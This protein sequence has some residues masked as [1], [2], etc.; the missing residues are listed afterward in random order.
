MRLGLLGGTFDPIHR[1]HLDAGRVARRSL[2]LDRVLLVPARVPP[3]RAGG[4][5]ASGYHRFAMAVLAAQDAEGFEVSDIELASPGPSYT[6]QTLREFRRL[7]LDASQMFFISGVDA[8]A[9]I[10]TWHDYPELL[11][12]AHWV[13]VARPGHA[14]A[15]LAARLPEVVGRFE[16]RDT[17]AIPPASTADRTRVWLV[18]A[19]TTDVS[20]TE[21]RRRIRANEP[22]DDL[23]PFAVTR[24]IRHH[25]LYQAPSPAGRL[26]DQE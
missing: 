14:I 21:L 10:A 2:G 19:T 8:F 18:E 3:H 26:H 5:H 24:H 6:A 23:A 15:D 13:V 4:P 12:L 17:D 16:C 7:G 1:G 9:D 11:D 20:S 25:G 22:F